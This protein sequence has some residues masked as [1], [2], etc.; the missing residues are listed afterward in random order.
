MKILIHAC[1]QRMWYVEEF[2]VPELRAQGAENIEIW[3][4]SVKN[5]AQICLQAL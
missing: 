5:Y 4:D 3:C 2:L 1:P